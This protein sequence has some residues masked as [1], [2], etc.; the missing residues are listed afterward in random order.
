MRLCRFGDNRLGLV[1]EDHVVDVTAV[2]DR[3]PIFSLP[4]TKA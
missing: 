1:Q 3:L 2:L 4:V